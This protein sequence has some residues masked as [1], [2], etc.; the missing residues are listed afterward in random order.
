M[1][2]CRGAGISSFSYQKD[3]IEAIL[4]GFFKNLEVDEW[5]LEDAESRAAAMADLATKYP[6]LVSQSKAITPNRDSRL[7]HRG[8]TA[9]IPLK[10][11]RMTLSSPS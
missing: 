11:E 9:L 5:E 10:L 3:E 2:W 6:S 7:F 8:N 1:A 4:P